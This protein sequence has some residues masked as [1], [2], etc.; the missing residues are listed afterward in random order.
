MS[1]ASAAARLAARR[2]MPSISGLKK[3]GQPPVTVTAPKRTTTRT[4][5]INTTITPAAHQLLEAITHHQRKT[6]GRKWARN[7]TIEAAL[8]AYA[9]EI[10][11]PPDA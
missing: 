7:D 5:H 3:E 1:E 6:H 4:L 8:A 2:P 11:L 10:K 9:R